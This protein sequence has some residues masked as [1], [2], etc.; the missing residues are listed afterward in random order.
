MENRIRLFQ[1]ANGKKWVVSIK[2]GTYC[3]NSCEH[4]YKHLASRLANKVS[5]ELNIG[6][7]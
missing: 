1:T 2:I 3:F 5:K 6:R 4:D 7:V